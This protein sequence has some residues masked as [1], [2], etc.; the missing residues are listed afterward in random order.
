MLLGSDTGIAN[1]DSMPLMVCN[2]QR[3]LIRETFKG[4]AER[5]KCTMRWF[6]GFKLHLTKNDRGE[7]LNFVFI[8]GNVVD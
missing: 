3:I 6:L 8:P 2:H 4:L 7:I 1:A 5:G